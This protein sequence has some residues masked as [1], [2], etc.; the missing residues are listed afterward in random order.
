M[1]MLVVL[2]ETREPFDVDFELEEVVKVEGNTGLVKLEDAI[3]AYL[4]LLQFNNTSL[5]LENL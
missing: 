2:N 3:D 5:F 4:S 1:G